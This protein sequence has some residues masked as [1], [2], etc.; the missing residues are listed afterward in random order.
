MIARPLRLLLAVLATALALSAL[1]S[2][3]SA[4]TASAPAADH[5][6]LLGIPG[7]T[8]DDIT[9]Q[10]TPALAAL[11]GHA[12][13]A[14]MS[15]RTVHPRAC[16]V[17]GWLTTGAGARSTDFRTD[18]A[19]AKPCPAPVPPTL[20]PDGAATVPDLPRIVEHNDTYG[21]NPRFGQLAASVT[22]TG[23]T[24]T[25][26]GPGA[27]Y[28]AADPTGRVQATYLPDPAAVDTALIERSA[29]TLVDLGGP[30]SPPTDTQGGTA[31][32][33]SRDFDRGHRLTEIDAQVARIAA[34]LPPRTQLVV[35]GL[36]DDTGTPH[37]RA[38]LVSGPGTKAHRA[39]GTEP[40]P[41][42]T[43]DNG[44]LTATSTRNDGLVQLTDL[45][46]SLLAPLGIDA[47]GELVGAVYTRVGSASGSTAVE[48]LRLFDVG[49]QASR[50]VRESW[51]FF[52][53]LT[54][55]PIA[56]AGVALWFAIRLGRSGKTAARRRVT[57]TAEWIGV[58]F[59]AVP[60]GSFL[61]ALVPWEKA[62]DP[63]WTLLGLTAAFSALLAVIALLGPWRSHPYGPAGV[64]AAATAVILA[65][66]VMVGS[67]LQLN[68]L[69]G[70]SPLVAGRFYGFGNVAWTIFAMAVLLA[71]AW[72]TARLILANRRRAAL[73]VLSVVGAIAVVADG[74]PAFGS[75]FG[76]V[77]ALIPGLAILGLLLTGTRISWVKVGLVALGAVVVI[78]TI[79]VLDW[80][81]PAGSRSHLGRFVQEIVD[82]N[83]GDTI[84][85]KIMG[86]LH[87][88]TGPFT[89]IIPVV[90]VVLIF[91]VLNPDKWRSP[92]LTR[93]FEAVPWLR[94][95][96]IACWLTAVVGYAVNDSGIQIPA[97]ALTIV[98][99]L[100]IAVIAATEARPRVD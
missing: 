57:K 87:S 85:R 99:P 36:A 34:A 44:Y 62:G 2:T 35:A 48:H 69:F 86:N 79:A 94:S 92:A 100:S 89:L 88:F 91:A 13:T 74:W 17:D 32:A 28:A 7:L 81:R 16:P 39:P 26:V 58:L 14:A 40:A 73:V 12:A 11:T 61:V 38:L 8:W 22:A 56:G 45:A 83:A 1:P 65:G 6:V 20:A 68:T 71:V 96:L 82:G 54:L 95:T 31:S 59:G 84:H 25:A 50:T 33:P 18:A 72:P 55:L 3:A 37:L 93:S 60:G 49:A 97:V 29:L 66:D 43:F 47:P 30:Y 15:V 76:G 24:V 19:T 70:L 4:A 63:A 9:P 21:Y 53:W 42:D 90:F 51:M 80:L 5:V 23:R 98:A 46:P 67:P 41:S 52:T 10:R 27:A 78:G 77:L 75:D 64:V